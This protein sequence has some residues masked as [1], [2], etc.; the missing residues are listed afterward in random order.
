MTERQLNTFFFTPHPL[1]RNRTKLSS[2]LGKEVSMRN[3]EPSPVGRL[4]KHV[5]AHFDEITSEELPQDMRELVEKLRQA[6]QVK[7]PKKPPRK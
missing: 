5:R 2:L 1:V 6:E 3:K 4:R 7:P